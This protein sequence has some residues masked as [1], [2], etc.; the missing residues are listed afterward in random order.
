MQE[1]QVG[2]ELYFIIEGEVE[3]LSGGERLGFL[4]EG[5]FFGES[6]VIET[7]FG[8]RGNGAEIRT[9]TVRATSGEVSLGFISKADIEEVLEQFPELEFKLKQFSKSG[10]ALSSK[11]RLSPHPDRPLL[12]H[13]LVARPMSCV[14][15]YFEVINHHTVG[16]LTIPRA[17]IKWV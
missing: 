9:R 14:P 17:S 11:A 1:G 15:G 5:S 2:S 12:P 7:M 10:S 3:V 8:R 13:L 16:S 6:P 4:G